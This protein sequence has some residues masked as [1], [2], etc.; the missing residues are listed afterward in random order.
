[1]RRST[2][3]GGSCAP[4]RDAGE[5]D[6]C[7]ALRICCDA[8]AIERTDTELEAAAVEATV[9]LRGVLTPRDGALE[10]LGTLRKRG[11]KIGLIS[12]A[13][14]E[15]AIIWPETTM[16]PFF[17]AAVF[18]SLEHRR[19][20]DPGLYCAVCERLGVAGNDCLYV[21]NGDGDELAGAVQAGMRAVLF[22]APGE[23]PGREAASWT[24][25]RISDLRA[26]IEI[27]GSA[28]APTV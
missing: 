25:A 16:V 9:F 13:N 11:L 2:A 6:A 15:T 14:V 5:L 12:D 4:L 19:K 1:M 27:A 7:R 17:H 26:V 3:S 8:S 22:T 23:S 24:G 18:S 28:K 20:P 21:G 10:T